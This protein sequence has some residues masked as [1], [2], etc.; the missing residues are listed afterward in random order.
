MSDLQQLHDKIAELEQ[1]NNELSFL[2]YSALLANSSLHD[3]DELVS[4]SVIRSLVLALDS[5]DPYT[6]GHSSRV[7]LYSLWIARELKIPEEECKHF[8]RAALMHDIGKIGVPDKILLKADSLDDEEFH[9]M[10]SH[11]TIG[12]RILSKMEPEERMLQATE[13]AKYH[14]EKMDGSGY[15]DGLSG[16]EIPFFAR[17]VAVADA[18]DAMTTD[19][20][21]SKGRSYWDGVQEIIRCKGTHFDPV[22]VE[23]FE[24]VMEHRDYLEGFHKLT[25]QA[26]ANKQ[27]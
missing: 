23:A 3:K 16:D 12:A 6:A 7:A 10:I 11:T 22:V 25:E 17:I 1:K 20:P 5:R 26:E 24:K 13:V 19:R 27:E 8:Y 2:L 14:H 4:M 18:F 9:I 15:P 21:Y